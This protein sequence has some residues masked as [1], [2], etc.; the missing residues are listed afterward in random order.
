MKILKKTVKILTIVALLIVAGV[1][2]VS[3]ASKNS[4]DTTELRIVDVS[5]LGDSVQLVYDLPLK[6]PQSDYQ[7]TMQPAIVG[8]QDTILMDEIVLNGKN[9]IKK[10]HRDHVLNHKDEPEQEYYPQK[11]RV[12]VLRDTM[13]MPVADYRWLLTDSLSICR[14]SQVKEGCCKIVEMDDECSRPYTYYEKQ[15]ESLPE[16]E[17]EEM[18]IPIDYRIPDTLTIRTIAENK[19]LVPADQYTPYDR[20]VSMNSREDVIYVTFAKDSFN[21]KPYYRH[22]GPRLASLVDA[23]N[24]IL[25]DTMAEVVKIQIIGMASLEGRESTNAN[26]AQKRAESLKR[27]IIGKTGA[28]EELFEV[29]NGGEGWA[30]FEWNMRNAEFSGKQSVLNIIANKSITADEKEKRIKRLQ[31]GKVFKWIKENILPEQ[32]NAG[33][34]RVFY[35]LNEDK[36]AE[37]INKAIGLMKEHKYYEALEVLEPY[38]DDP[39]AY[40]AM[41]MAYHMTGN[42]EKAREMWEKQ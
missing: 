9:N 20:S 18:M 13:M 15:L 21:V 31:N 40:K 25:A 10:L 4:A 16:E 41:G 30:E 14:M 27:Y 35:K 1:V 6:R 2:S 11:L 34:M 38:D 5:L 12:R 26:L 23:V 17:Q 28:A 42:E 19:M 8:S 3:A 7:V 33:Y 37:A 36:A 32:R 24:T 39:R 22:N 29:C